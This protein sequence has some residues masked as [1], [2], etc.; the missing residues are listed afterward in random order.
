MGGIAQLFVGTCSVWF[1]LFGSLFATCYVGRPKR[2][3]D[4]GE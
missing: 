3:Q 4:V 2:I 1:L